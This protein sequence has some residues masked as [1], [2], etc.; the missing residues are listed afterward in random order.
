MKT[1]ALTIFFVFILLSILIFGRVI[2]QEFVYLFESFRS[3]QYSLDTS[4]VPLGSTVRLI[5]PVN[6]VFGLV[7]PKINANARVFQGVEINDSFSLPPLLNKGVAQKKGSAYPGER[8]VVFLVAHGDY[9]FYNLPNYNQA[10]Y[11]A[12]KLRK[13]D[14]IEVFYR[15]ARYTYKVKESMVIDSKEVPGYIKTLTSQGD[16]RLLVLQTVNSWD[17]VSNPL[18]IVAEYVPKTE[19]G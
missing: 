10:F 18:F 5:S 7:I 2:R 17:L 1:T 12:N 9:K 15:D 14:L 13:G 4:S 8:G 6:T 16:R 11:L 19:R 3:I